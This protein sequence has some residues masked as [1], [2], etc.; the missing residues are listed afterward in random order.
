MKWDE[1]S[2]YFINWYKFCKFQ[3]NDL[4]EYKTDVGIY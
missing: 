2:S 3:E 4:I 1:S